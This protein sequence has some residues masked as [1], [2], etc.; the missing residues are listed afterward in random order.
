MLAVTAL[1]RLIDAAYE[2][3]SLIVTSNL[4]PA[5]FDTIFPKGLAAAAVDR[6]CTTPTSSSPRADLIASARRSKVEAFGRSSLLPDDAAMRL[7][8]G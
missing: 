5:R 7:T 8:G 2:K 4:H 3:R 1:Y 6:S